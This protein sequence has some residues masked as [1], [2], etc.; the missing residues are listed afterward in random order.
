MKSSKKI[1]LCLVVFLLGWAAAG[2]A[3]EI[4]V[5][6]R[7][8]VYDQNGEYFL[9][10]S[11]IP[12]KIK[13]LSESIP[14]KAEYES[15]EQYAARIQPYE[16]KRQEVYDAE[17]SITLAPSPYLF[18]RETDM[19]LFVLQ[20]PFPVYR[21][22]DFIST[23]T[24]EYAYEA[25]PEDMQALAGEKIDVKIKIYFKIL[26]DNT[27]TITKTVLIFNNKKMHQWE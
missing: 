25:P 27:T 10:F 9:D 4:K 19:Y 20:F 11:Q 13:A 18:S 6:V 21:T 8:D 24:I 1:G 23:Q 7:G 12:S 26:R 16:D 5:D 3:N 17:Y 2:A 14:E 15:D 22:D